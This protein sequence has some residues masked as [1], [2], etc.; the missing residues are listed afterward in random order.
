MVDFA[1]SR[2]HSAER[3]AVPYSAIECLLVVVITS[4]RRKTTRIV[5]AGALAAAVGVLTTP[6]VMADPDTPGPT[7]SAPRAA[8]A[9]KAPGLR[10]KVLMRD[11]QYPWDIAVL[12]NGA[13][14]VTE[15]DR[16]RITL[17]RTDGSSKVLARTSRGFWHGGETGLMSIVA[18]PNASKNRR[19]YV[20]TGF[21]GA[22]GPQVRV[23]P[24]KLSPAYNRAK[25][26]RPLL[27]GIQ[28][29]SGRHGGCRLRF[30]S[31]DRLYVGTGDAAVNTNPQNTRSLN[32]KVLRLSRITGKPSPQNPWSHA[33][34]KNR[35]YVY[36]YGHRNVQGLAFRGRDQHMWSV[37]HGSTRD[38]EVNRLARGGN[39]GWDPGP[40]YDESTP[41]TEH[42]LPGRQISARWRSGN[43]TIATSGAVWVRGDKW[44][45]YEGTL[46]VC[47][48]KASKLVFMKFSK[49]GRLLWTR[50][51]AAMSGDFGRLRSVVL[52]EHN[53]LL[54]TT[55][56]GSGDRV[57]RVS[58]K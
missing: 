13:L 11:L 12:P 17:R 25:R 52:S 24:F 35:R 40:G 44:G 33:V 50:T 20:C 36:T 28:T 6:D 54:V 30:D 8:A 22:S 55:S 34:N 39:Y 38:D 3:H 29:T 23:Y 56:N 57:V 49:Q 46:A 19:F 32:G 26:L 45:A 43:S 41:M 48:L 47:A 9:S 18:D 15:R 14:L 37:E 51:P 7:A 4:S 1:G 10:T 5:V 27:T 31:K 42:S 21:N 2:Q 58:P 53:N 16:E